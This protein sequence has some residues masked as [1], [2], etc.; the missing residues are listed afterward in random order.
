MKTSQRI[1]ST[2]IATLIVAL[3]CHPASAAT[4]TWDGADPITSGAQGGGGTWDSNSSVN[5]WNGTSD[6]VWPA[7]SS[8]ADAA[9]FAGISGTVT[10][11][12]GVTA[13][14]LTFNTTGYT[15]TGGTLTLDGSSPTI[16]LGTGVST[17]IESV[18]AGSGGLTKSGSGALTLAGANTFTGTATVSAGKLIVSNNNTI[19]SLAIGNSAGTAGAFYLTSGT[20]TRS[21]GNADSFAVD[22]YG[23]MNISGGEL[24]GISVWQGGQNGTYT[25]IGVITQ[26]GGAMTVTNAQPFVLAGVNVGGCTGVLNLDGGTMSLA[27]SQMAVGWDSSPSGRGEFNISGGSATAS[28]LAFKG[29]T[30][31]ILNLL[32]GTLAV[33]SVATGGTAASA[34][35]NFNGGTLRAAQNG[36]TLINLATVGSQN[37]VFIYSGGATIDTNGNSVSI[38]NSLNAPT[39]N[40]L[41]S[42]ALTGS[43]AGYIG[44]PAVQITGGG[45]SGA[46]ARANIDANGVVTGIVITNPGTGYTSAPTVAL[47]GGGAGTAAT[48]GTVSLAVNA[49]GGLTKIGLGTL[50][51][52]ASSTFTGDTIVNS[53]TLAISHSLALQN[54]AFNTSG[55]GNLALSITNPTFGGLKG[56]TALATAIN[57]GYGS[58]SS[59]T[60][61]SGIGVTNT[62]SGKIANGASGMTLTKNGAGTQILS[63]SNSYTGTTTVNS[64]NLSISG[65]GTLGATSAALTIN[66]GILD[67]GATSQTVAAVTIAGGV[68]QSGTLTGSSFAGQ[69]GTVSAVLAAA[70]N[71]TKST[72]GTLTLTGANTFAGST[73]VTGGK[74]IVSNNLTTSSLAI[75]TSGALYLTSGTLTRSVTHEDLAYS[76]YGYLNISGG[77]LTGAAIWQQLGTGVITQS[78]GTFASTAAQP[79]VLGGLNTAGGTGVFNLDGG[80]LTVATGQ[81]MAVGWDTNTSGRGE[82]NI[83]GGSATATQFVFK[84]ATTGVLKL[85]SGTLSVN[86]VSTATLNQNANSVGFVNFN[87]GTLQATQNGTL[88]NLGT[89]GTQNN[90]FIYPGG[91]TI[92][93]NGNSVSIANSLNAPTGNGLS[94][95]ALTG[96]GAGYIGQPYVQITGGGGSGATARATLDANGVVT[97]IVI[98]NPGTGYTTAP[99]VTLVG[100]GAGTAATVGTVNLAANAGGGLTKTGLGTLTL[101][102]SNTFTGDTI[103][104]SGTLMISHALALQN[105]AFNT[106]GAGIL[107]LSVTNPTFGGLK[108]STALAAAINSSYGNVSSLTINSGMA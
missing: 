49:G 2:N 11:T 56:S 21:S 95:I 48:I 99:T 5:W 90:V 24:A 93:T 36:A 18:I 74:L 60:I 45:G 86:S 35:V 103:L 97:G 78:G 65:V 71:F 84:G 81:S 43:G 15:L 28:F 33:N 27:G 82:F 92:D 73:T 85:L 7:A 20:V 12:G 39:G 52:S 70:G 3:L 37:N 55:A 69:S 10:L 47:V 8:G 23:Y 63:G 80:T 4:Y 75:G 53:G 30:T 50:T 100:G 42:I 1:L 58:A 101:S 87:G 38:A 44:E 25:G 29:A 32:G 102:G 106:S 54:S 57:S 104:N 68:I 88:I 14:S 76:G 40:G 79:F 98:T 91:A 22:G 77:L 96:N 64:G 61:N 67:L 107:A 9:V 72:A 6:V 89:V 94:S 66:G 105:S 31:G 19:S 59:L 108:G 16:T 26:S 83:N 62:Y 41:S 13:H 34:F 51:L 17:S 46:T